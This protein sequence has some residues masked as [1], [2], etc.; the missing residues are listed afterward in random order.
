MEYVQERITTLHDFGGADPAAPTDR[1]TVV[2]P[3]A[4]RDHAS[5]AAERVFS[6]LESVDPAQVLVALRADPD[7]V[8]QVRTWLDGFDLTVEIL[9]CDAP[10][11]V[12]GIDDAGLNGQRGK[13]RDVWLALGVA[14]DRSEFVVV[15]DADATSYAATHVPRLLF[16]LA[17]GFAFSKGYYARVE[18]N[19]L[20]GRLNRLFYVPLVRTLAETHDADILEYLGAFRYALAGE[21]AMTADLARAVRAPRTWGLEV[22]TLGG[23]FEHAGFAG[24]AQVD[25]GRHEHDHRSVSGP[26]GLGE[27]CRSVGNALWRVLADAGVDV[28]FETLPERYRERAKILIEQYASDAAFNGMEYDRGGEREQ[29]G[30]YA[31]TIAP[32][33]P[34]TRLPTWSDAPMSAERVLELSREG[35][36]E[37]V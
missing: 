12:E 24:T 19:R 33:E 5:L 10:P 8:G 23:A 4:E 14:A 32:P 28:D 20:Y 21:F 26:A 17:S 2:V 36:A 3:M 27:M 13:G 35:L 29:V 15:H 7:H 18:N 1:A 25:L 31:E 34:D 30:T 6:T 11:L 16:P 22:G 37:Q 9:W